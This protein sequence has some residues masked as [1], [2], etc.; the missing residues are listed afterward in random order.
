MIRFIKLR[1]EHLEQVLEWRTQEDVTRFMNTDI[2]KDMVKQK[3][4]FNRISHSLTDAYWI[5][6]IKGQLVGIICLNGMDHVNKRTSW[7]FYIGEEK[8]RLYGG[9]IPP[10]FYNY[11]F[12][13]YVFHKI[14]AEVMEGNENVIK[15]NL[16][17]GY[18]MVGV[19]KEHIFKNSS[20]YDLHLLE[21][22]KSDWITQN[23]F[24]KYK[25]AFEE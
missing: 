9:I 20:C 2:E 13:T 11:V 4:W 1:E 8:Y 12:S 25:A 10:Y 21:L 16:L 5:I 23:K 3:E 14:T 15:L 17:H 22:L 18:R 19:Y 6:E 7:G 24:Q